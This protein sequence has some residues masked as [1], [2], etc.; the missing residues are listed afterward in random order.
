[1]FK[2]AA[3]SEPV[4]VGSDY[5]RIHPLHIQEVEFNQEFKRLIATKEQQVYRK[6]VVH[7]DRLIAIAHPELVKMRQELLE[8]PF[9]EYSQPMELQV[10]R[11]NALGGEYEMREELMNDL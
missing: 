6:Y 2:I 4:Q 3:L 10:V 9:L 7:I 1:M 8:L 5:F 11:E